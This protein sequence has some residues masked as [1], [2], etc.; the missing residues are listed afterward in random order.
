MKDD[1]IPESWDLYD[2]RDLAWLISLESEGSRDPKKLLPKDAQPEGKSD[3]PQSQIKPNTNNRDPEE[4]ERPKQNLKPDYAEEKISKP[5]PI[6][7]STGESGENKKTL[8]SKKSK[9]VIN[10]LGQSKAFHRLMPK[11]ELHRRVKLNIK[12][13]VNLTASTNGIVIPVFSNEKQHNG[14][15][16]FLMSNGS[17][18]EPYRETARELIQI[19]KESGAFKSITDE[20]ILI[21]LVAGRNEFPELDSYIRAGKDTLVILFHD[22]VG[23][24]ISY[25]TGKE[26]FEN[27]QRKS[28]S[29]RFCWLHPW[30]EEYWRRTAVSN[31]TPTRFTK[32]WDANAL[33]VPVVPIEKK[34]KPD[35]PLESGLLNLENWYFDKVNKRIATRV[36]YQP[37]MDAPEVNDSQVGIEDFKN[38]VD[39]FLYAA[40]PEVTDL[41]SLTVPMVNG[42]DVDTIMAFAEDL[43]P[44][45]GDVRYHMAALLTSG[46]FSISKNHENLPDKQPSKR[47]LKFVDDD[48]YAWNEIHKQTGSV[49]LEKI[50]RRF[51]ELSEKNIIPEGYKTLDLISGDIAKGENDNPLAKDYRA[52]HIKLGLIE[53]SQESVSIAGL[54]DANNDEDEVD[55]SESRTVAS[56]ADFFNEQEMTPEEV[57]EFLEQT[58]QANELIRQ[59]IFSY[60]PD[61]ESSEAPSKRDVVAALYKGVES[62]L[63]S[64]SHAFLDLHAAVIRDAAKKYLEELR[65][66]SWISKFREMYFKRYLFAYRENKFLSDSKENVKQSESS[67]A[68]FIVSGVRELQMNFPIIKFKE[69]NIPSDLNKDLEEILDLRNR[70]VHK[71][72]RGQDSNLDLELSSKKLKDI[73]SKIQPYGS[74]YY[75]KIIVELLRKLDKYA[76]NKTSVTFFDSPQPD[77]YGVERFYEE[78]DDWWNVDYLSKDEITEELLRLHDG[79]PSKARLDGVG[80]IDHKGNWQEYGPSERI[81][82]SIGYI[83]D[84]GDWQLKDTLNPMYEDPVGPLFYRLNYDS[85]NPLENFIRL[86]TQLTKVVELCLPFLRDKEFRA[87]DDISIRDGHVLRVLF[88]REEYE[89]GGLLLDQENVRLS[90]LFKI[91]RSWIH[92][93]S[94]PFTEEDFNSGCS[95]PFFPKFWASTDTDTYS[96]FI[97]PFLKSRISINNLTLP[98]QET[99]SPKS[100]YDIRRM[101]ILLSETREYGSSEVVYS[102]LFELI[103]SLN[104]FCQPAKR[105]FLNQAQTSKLVNWIKQLL[106]GFKFSSLPHTVSISGSR[107]PIKENALLEKLLI[108]WIESHV[109]KIELFFNPDHSSDEITTEILERLLIGTNVQF[110][111]SLPPLVKVQDLSGRDSDPFPIVDFCGEWAAFGPNNPFHENP[112]FFFLTRPLFSD[113]N[114]EVSF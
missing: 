106:E 103:L 43:F 52:L 99:G 75:E 98:V 95:N 64:C 107:A 89:K 25:E 70:L 22:G 24:A 77:S 12:E 100:S 65:S 10:R 66:S 59:D 92:N 73:A 87:F 19:A 61:P 81:D 27:I 1:S 96:L 58:I 71:G 3:I 67:D 60:P 85:D 102:R 18:M 112:I 33:T 30:P 74:K 20:P 4:I 9:S 94:F 2:L 93:S 49:Q 31:I 34:S 48:N 16:I 114:D 113:L 56:A 90:K 108:H 15:L 8:A 42:F 21:P 78:G 82:D 46:I 69:M 86:N 97:P 37:G 47:T 55:E 91:I 80:F 51:H 53:E 84:N 13:T 5:Q 26:L 88:D 35:G 54:A 11:R 41:L 101:I 50:I 79:D 32:T 72:D 23:D 36:L 105:K 44:Q 45:I 110:L 109:P 76:S 14:N 17:A 39:D 63:K 40:S 29:T 38:H 7:S 6:L 83:D 57:V 68:N 104:Y 28:N 111:K 62:N